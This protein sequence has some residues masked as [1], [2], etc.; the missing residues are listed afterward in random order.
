MVFH[1]RSEGKQP[2]SKERRKTARLTSPQKTPTLSQ[3]R[4]QLRRILAVYA[5]YKGNKKKEKKRTH[6]R[7]QK[8]KNSKAVTTV[9]IGR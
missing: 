4:S 9:S 1:Y 3:S 7:R 5:K 8:K 2:G 6:T